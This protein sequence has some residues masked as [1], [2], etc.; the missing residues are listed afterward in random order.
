MA[1]HKIY[2]KAESIKL[3]AD[4]DSNRN[5]ITDAWSD[6]AKCFQRAANKTVQSIIVNEDTSVNLHNHGKIRERNIWANHSIVKDINWLRNHLHHCNKFLGQQILSQTSIDINIQINRINNKYGT[7]IAHINNSWDLQW[8]KSARKEYYALNH[9]LKQEHK[10]L[11]NNRSKQIL[12]TAIKQLMEEK[13]N[14]LHHYLI[15]TREQ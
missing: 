6:I 12:I 3:T 1:K 14:L 10:K 7:H 11:R 5:L 4:K 15:E 13:G 8:S 9:I 2:N